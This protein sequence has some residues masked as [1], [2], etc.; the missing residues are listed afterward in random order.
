MRHDP[1]VAQPAWYRLGVLSQTHGAAVA[2]A[3]TALL[4]L[5]TLP[6]FLQYRYSLEWNFM[7][8]RAGPCTS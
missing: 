3:L 6:W 2:A 7:T 1:A 4:L 5:P 8:P